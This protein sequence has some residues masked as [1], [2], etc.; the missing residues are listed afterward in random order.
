MDAA[1]TDRVA[2]DLFPK[3]SSLCHGPTLTDRARTLTSVFDAHAVA[4]R[5]RLPDTRR[6]YRYYPRRLTDVTLA[7]GARLWQFLRRPSAAGVTLAK[8]ERLAAWLAPFADLDAAGTQTPPGSPD[9]WVDQRS[10]VA[11]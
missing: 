8:R 3:F 5:Y 7:Y 2:A 10:I 4:T 9:P 6:V 1:L 11:R